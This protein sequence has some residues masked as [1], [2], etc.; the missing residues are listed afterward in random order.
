MQWNIPP[1]LQSMYRSD[2]RLRS[3]V[4]CSVCE[5]RD[6]Q[7]SVELPELLV[8]QLERLAESE[9]T[10]ATDLIRRW[11]EEGFERARSHAGCGTRVALP[12]IPAAETGPIR[13]IYGSDLDEW[14]VRDDLAS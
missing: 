9:G 12:L 4:V 1:D 11:I 14:S 2:E 3:C 8:E 5:N 6:M 13:P 7:T 10:T